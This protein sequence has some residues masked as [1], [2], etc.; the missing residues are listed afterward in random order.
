[1]YRIAFI[2]IAALAVAA[3]LL[4]GTLNSEV[5]ALDLLWVQLE[6]PLGLIV[7]GAVTAGL[8]LGLVLAWF[9]SILPLRA[10]LRRAGR[11]DGGFE[12]AGS[13]KRIDD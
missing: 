13:L 8:L 5:A 6:W 4:I 10:R 11:K 1:L 9:F 3:G 2:L 7:L 12:A